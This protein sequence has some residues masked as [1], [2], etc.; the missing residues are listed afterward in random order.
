MKLATIA[1]AAALPLAAQAQQQFPAVLAGHA[2]LPAKTIIAPPQDAPESMRVSGKYTAPDGKRRDAPETIQGT[3]FLSDKAA[4]RPTGVSL[5]FKGQPVQGFSGIK[6]MKDGTFWVLTDNGYGSKANSPDAMLMFH[7]VRVDWKSGGVTLLRTVFLH[8]PDRKVPFA[9]VNEGTTK[10]Y[11]TGADFDPESMQF[12]GDSVWFGDELGPYLVRTD[13]N[14]KVLAVYETLLDGRVLRS[15]DHY[16]VTTPAVPGAFTTPVRR[17][18]G[19]EGMA[20]SKDGRFLY[21][22]LEG[23]LWIEAEK[24][25]EGKDGREFLRI[26]EFDVAKGEWTGRSWKYLLEANGNNIGDFNMIDADTGLIIERDNGEGTADEACNG[27]PR[28][29]CQNVPAKF[30]RVYKVSLADADAEGFVKKI[31]FIDL[32]DIDDP[33]G[34]AKRGGKG[35]K[36]TFPFVTIEDVDVVDADHIVVANDNNLPYSSGRKVGVQDD[37]E[38]IL[39]RVPE[40]LRAR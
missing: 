38:F 6:A 12:V 1:L 29:D 34:V 24:R 23:P 32:M 18:R 10:R 2:Y 7:Q 28:P 37:N 27:P 11:L 33:K 19:Y 14:G 3:S 20:A 8:D 16:T 21:P 39:L 9:I 30:K 15:P 25:W 40:L 31:G 5:P 26:L 35:G 17:S 13:R 4:P 36:F 22:L